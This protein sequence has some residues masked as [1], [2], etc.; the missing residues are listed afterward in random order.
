MYLIKE[1]MVIIG[2]TVGLYL[3]KIR[4]IIEE[5]HAD[6]RVVQVLALHGQ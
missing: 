5:I 4:Q 2:F 3:F 6:G 1:V